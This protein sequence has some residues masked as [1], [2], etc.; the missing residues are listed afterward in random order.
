[1]TPRRTIAVLSSIVA[2][3]VLMSS[4]VVAQDESASPDVAAA[5]SSR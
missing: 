2:L 3:L 1:M 5:R 4:G